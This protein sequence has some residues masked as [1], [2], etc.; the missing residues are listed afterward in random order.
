MVCRVLQCEVRQQ[1]D[2]VSARI[3]QL[4][5]QNNATN[6]REISNARHT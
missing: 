5:E 4:T 1:L 3:D 2:R 6:R